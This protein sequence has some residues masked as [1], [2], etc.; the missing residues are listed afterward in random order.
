[1][2]TMVAQNALILGPLLLIGL[3]SSSGMQSTI[4]QRRAA[5]GTNPATGEFEEIEVSDEAPF[6]A[7]CFK[8]ATD[9]FV[10]RLIY[11]RIYSGVVKTGDAVFNSARGKRERLGR[12]L[13]MHAN[14]REDITEAD[15]GSIV[16]ALLYE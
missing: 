4:S 6:C 16:A 7:L 11:L 14:R 12:L 9:P 8:I 10:G 1:M 3:C 15:T 13:L 2:P 5:R